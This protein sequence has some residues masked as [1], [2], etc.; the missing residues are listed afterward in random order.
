MPGP[1]LRDTR[2]RLGLTQAAIAAALGV[3][4]RC[5]QRWEATSLPRTRA[6]MIR[7]AL[8]ALGA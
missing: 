4:L 1:E 2:H 8:G 5:Y 7:L 6:T 3:S